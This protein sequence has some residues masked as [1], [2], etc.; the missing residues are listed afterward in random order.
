MGGDDQSFDIAEPLAATTPG[1]ILPIPAER[2]PAG[3]TLPDENASM[4]DTYG[5]R[6]EGPQQAFVRDF[7][8]R[9]ACRTD[10]P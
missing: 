8:L 3:G 1:D 4:Y 7:V 5:Q 6:P 9:K 2:A 10:G